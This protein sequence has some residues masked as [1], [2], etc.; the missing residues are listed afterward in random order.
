MSV[1]KAVHR[2]N[3]NLHEL[4]ADKQK[5][6]THVKAEKSQL[7]AIDH[8]QQQYIDQFQHP[9][10][11]LTAK[12]AGVRAKYDPLIAKDKRE[13]THDRHVAL[14]HLHAAEER[15]GLKE[16]NRD[17]KALGLKPLKHA[18]CNLKTVQ[19]CAKY[20]LQSKN[21]SFW[22]GL[23]SGSDRKNVERLARGE[24]AYVPATGG[25]VRPKLKLMQALVA[26]SKH[27]HI[28]INAL[29]GGTHSTGSNH[30]RGTA[31]D[32][33][34]STGNHSMIEHIARRYGGIR[35]YETDHIHL[36]F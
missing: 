19:G 8:Q 4:K 13:V 5:L 11:E 17:R 24:K 15:M 29:T 14:S 6:A 27:G 34:L 18:V 26:M 35:N 10:A 20:L 32:L 1:P 36:D 25:H 21:V 9:S 7:S 3:L 16:T 12:A 30:Y 23:S 2:L 33:D 31:V 22:S 28:M